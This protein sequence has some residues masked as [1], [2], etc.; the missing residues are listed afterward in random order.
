LSRRDFAAGLAALLVGSAARS[1]SARDAEV[2]LDL[3][4]KL[5]GKVAAYDRNFEQRT[6]GRVLVVLVVSRG[7]ARSERAAAQLISAFSG[8]GSIAGK[9]HDVL[10][11][12]YRNAADLAGECRNRRAGIVY[13]TPGLDQQ[14]DAISEALSG[15]DLL[16]VAAVPS[17]VPRGVVLG[18]RLVSAKPK[19]LIHLEQA[20]RQNVAF[21]ADFLKLA[22]VIR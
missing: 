19:M 6:G 13:L 11:L 3:Q 18:F 8:I 5:V 22:E 10:Q 12:P 14:I 7:Q 1:A 15:L 16:S 21:K 2:P 20:K 9:P 4:A 17:Y